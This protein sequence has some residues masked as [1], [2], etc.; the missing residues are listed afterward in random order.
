[1]EIIKK[2][3]H[4]YE[5]L[6]V[7]RDLSK[8]F[9]TSVLIILAFCSAA[10]GQRKE[11]ILNR[12][13]RKPVK[14]SGSSSIGAEQ[15]SLGLGL[16]MEYGFFGCKTTFFPTKGLGAMFGAG[17]GPERGWWNAGIK[18]RPGEDLIKYV[19]PSMLVLYGTNTLIVV[20]G[21]TELNKTFNGLT[22]GLGIDKRRFKHGYWSVAI[23]LPIISSEVENYQRFLEDTHGLEFEE[24]GFPVKIS[25]GYNFVLSTTRRK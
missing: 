6:K 4:L 25:L 24:M 15:F 14:S 7:N 18:W 23:L 19:Q 17:V 3:F 9:F 21:A 22:I 2:G 1:M 5:I 12:I 8:A 10:Q 13:N 11:G 20:N 16:G